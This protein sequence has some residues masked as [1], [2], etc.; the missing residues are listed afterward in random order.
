[1][2]G[3]VHNFI[4]LRILSVE[5]KLSDCSIKL[6]C[7]FYRCDVTLELTDWQHYCK[8]VLATINYNSISVQFNVHFLCRLIDF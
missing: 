7:S 3:N 6:Q 5:L 8:C 1:M 2:P 4:L